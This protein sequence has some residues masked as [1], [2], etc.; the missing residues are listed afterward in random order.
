MRKGSPIRLCG[1]WWT[2]AGMSGWAYRKIVSLAYLVI[3]IV[4]AI[5]VR[6]KNAQGRKKVASFP[7]FCG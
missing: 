5:Y 7:W 6:A 2:S 3:V 1:F 4:L